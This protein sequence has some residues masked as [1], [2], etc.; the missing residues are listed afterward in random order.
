VF[1][2]GSC[3]TGVPVSNDSIKG[4]V[5]PRTGFPRL[6]TLPRSSSA[7]RLRF[8]AFFWLRSAIKYGSRSLRCF[9]RSSS[10]LLFWSMEL[11]EKVRNGMVDCRGV[12]AAGRQLASDWHHSPSHVPPGARRHGNV[13]IRGGMMAMCN[14]MRGAPKLPRRQASGNHARRNVCP[15]RCALAATREYRQSVVPSTR[16]STATI[17][18][19]S[20]RRPA[21][22]APNRHHGS[23]QP[24]RDLQP[25]PAGH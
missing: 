12:E 23:Q 25:Q 15:R 9:A 17:S 7:R 8:A 11:D 3:L 19:I 14:A 21:S 10:S 16:S 5:T 24:P 18:T 13:G 6:A 20:L 2:P 22:A 1:L 4:V